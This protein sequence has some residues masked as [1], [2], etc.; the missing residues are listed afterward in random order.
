MPMKI[1]V[2]VRKI[3]TCWSGPQKTEPLEQHRQQT[4]G[5]QN[6]DPGVNADQERGPE[7]QDDQHHQRR[8][9]G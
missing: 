2:S 4:F 9:D 8:A 3:L 1:A 7:R 5:L 6:T